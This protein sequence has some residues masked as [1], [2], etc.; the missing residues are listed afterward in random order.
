MRAITWQQANAR[1]LAH[2][3]LTTPFAADATVADVAVAMSGVHAQILSAAEVSVALR[4]EG[5][6]RS[7]VR[8]ALW[9]ERAS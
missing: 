9:D 2:H 5:A 1:R 7:D 3:G 6:K 8:R 4:V